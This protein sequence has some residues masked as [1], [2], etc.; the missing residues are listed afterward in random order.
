MRNRRLGLAALG[1]LA[2]IVAPAG[3]PVSAQEKPQKKPGTPAKEPAPG[4]E[5]MPTPKSMKVELVLKD[6]AGKEVRKLSAESAAGKEG[7]QGL[8]AYAE[9]VP[10]PDTLA[11][12]IVAEN[13][14]QLELQIKDATKK[15]K[16][17]GVSLSLMGDGE[18]SMLSW[19]GGPDACT[20]S[21]GSF[22]GKDGKLTV[23]CR[24]VGTQLGVPHS[25]VATVT[26]DDCPKF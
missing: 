3:R 25:L 21:S 5:K 23:T 13:T 4:H 18:K 15:P 16:V 7:V 12:A 10:A 17:D 19:S 26:L 1:A 20:L 2:F 14:W 22:D 11:V 8:C 6:A 24:Q 9:S